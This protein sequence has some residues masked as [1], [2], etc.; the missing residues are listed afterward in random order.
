MRAWTIKSARTRRYL[1][2]YPSI[3][4]SR[5][6]HSIFCCA[7]VLQRRNLAKSLTSANSM[8]DDISSPVMACLSVPW[9]FVSMWLLG[10][11]V[12][13]LWISFSSCLFGITFIFGGIVRVSHCVYDTG[14]MCTSHHRPSPHPPRV[15]C[16]YWQ[17]YFES[18]IYL[19]S[20]HPFDVGDWLCIEGDW[21]QVSSIQLGR[22]L[23]RNI[24]GKEAYWRT[25]VLRNTHPLEN[26]TRSVYERRKHS[27]PPPLAR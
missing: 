9:F 24:E 2:S 5:A 16:Y 7:T 20:I 15:C 6:T 26:L 3:G 19:F 22:T 23:L 12:Y 10:L 14:E 8:V 18:A 13:T 11:D 21:H 17:D 4:R 1:S 27:L 25:T